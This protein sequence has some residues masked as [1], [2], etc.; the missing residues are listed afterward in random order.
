MCYSASCTNEAA[1][2][3]GMDSFWSSP[4]ISLTMLHQC[5]CRAAFKVAWRAFPLASRGTRIVSC[6]RIL[7]CILGENMDREQKLYLLPLLSIL[8]PDVILLVSL[9][10]VA[11]SHTHTREQEDSHKRDHNPWLEAVVT[12]EPA[13]AVEA[14]TQQQPVR[15]PSPSH[16]LSHTWHRHTCVLPELK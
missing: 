11:Y 3:R 5:F 15:L 14:H 8:S 16:Q 13:V 2:R 9:L 7:V 10:K 12:R 6:H 4:L 1:K